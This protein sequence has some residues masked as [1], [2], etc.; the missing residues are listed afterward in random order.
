MN[1]HYFKEDTSLAHHYQEVTCTLR[2]HT[3]VFQTDSG[4]FSK[5]GVDY[6]SQALI[7]AF[8]QDMLSQVSGP[9][10]DVGC[11]YGPLGLF[12]AA[13]T[14][15]TVDMVD[16]NPRALEMAKINAEKNKITNV[17]IF[18]SDMF[19][20]VPRTDYAAIISN[21]PIRAGKKKVHEV[22]EKSYD[23]LAS[24]GFLIVVIQKKQGAGSAKAKMESVF[25]NVCILA[26]DK[27]YYILMSQKEA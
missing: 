14:D 4:I 23:H 15:R 5:N 26:R 2:A 19:S 16:I 6:G 3:L 24:G 9:I 7:K 12:L 10:L 17:H 11:G 21:P 25:G 1:S 20:K 22:L 8:P 13:S 18:E 27:G